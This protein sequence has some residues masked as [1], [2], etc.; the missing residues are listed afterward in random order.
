MHYGHF[1]WMQLQLRPQNPVSCILWQVGLLEQPSHRLAWTLEHPVLVIENCFFWSERPTRS[2]CILLTARFAKLVYHISHRITM[3]NLCVWK[4]LLEI[5]L[6]V[7]R[8][9]IT[10]TKH[11]LHQEYTLFDRQHHCRTAKQLTLLSLRHWCPK[12]YCALEY[13]AHSTGT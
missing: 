9:F 13:T 4:L 7:L 12:S 1:V 3:G 2:G 10:V 8:V 5:L 11:M 6:N